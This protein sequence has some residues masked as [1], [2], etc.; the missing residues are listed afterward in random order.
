MKKAI[1]TSRAGF[2][3]IELLIVVLIVG[4]LA[5]VA[6]PLYIGYTRDA[7][8]AEA[9][10]LAGSGL[11][12]AQ[13]CAQTNPTAESTECTLAKL[14]NRIG[15]GSTGG[16]GDGRWTLTIPTVVDFDP[17]ATPPKFTAGQILVAGV[18]GKNTEAMA[19]AIFVNA[20]GSVQ[21]RCNTTAATVAA[22]DPV[23]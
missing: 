21:T 19:A 14:A 8:L 9:K 22:T 16:T 7:R 3:L 4:I 6:V 1:I 11:T 17:A 20:D 15:V 18:A 23:C 13:G 5:A 2:T 10:S 12:A